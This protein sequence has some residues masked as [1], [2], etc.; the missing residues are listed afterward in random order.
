MNSLT[1]TRQLEGAVLALFIANPCLLSSPDRA[2]RARALARDIVLFSWALTVPLYS[3]L[4]K[5]VPTSCW[6]T[7]A[8]RLRGRYLRWTSI[9]SPGGVEVLLTASCYRKRETLLQLCASWLQ[10]FTFI[11]YRFQENSERQGE[12]K[13]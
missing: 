3:L 9:P 2:F 10:G 7:L 13:F 8:N 12:K 11:Y 1:Y 5:W 6:E 4:Y